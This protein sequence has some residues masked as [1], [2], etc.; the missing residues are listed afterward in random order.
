MK[1]E[2]EVLNSLTNIED[3]ILGQE[4]II[5]L[6]R[7]FHDKESYERHMRVLWITRNLL[8]DKVDENHQELFP[9]FDT[10]NNLISCLLFADEHHLLN[11]KKHYS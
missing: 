10:L 2:V 3:V 1:N 6:K 8:G 4:A 7:M 11:L 5:M 9:L